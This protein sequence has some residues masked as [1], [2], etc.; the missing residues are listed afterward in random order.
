VSF[1]HFLTIGHLDHECLARGEAGALR[2]MNPELRAVILDRAD[3]GS[4]RDSNG[5]V[6]F[7][8]AG[9][10][11]TMAGEIARLP[12]HEPRLN[13]SAVALALIAL[14][15]GHDAADVE[16]A[17]AVPRGELESDARIQM[18]SPVVVPDAD[19]PSEDE[20][21]ALVDHVLRAAAALAPCV[22][23]ARLT[24]APHAQWTVS[25][26][27]AATTQVLDQSAGTFRM[28]LAR[29][30]CQY[31]D[32]QVYGG[33]TRRHLRVGARDYAAAFFLSNEAL[34]GF[35]VQIHLAPLT[36]SDSH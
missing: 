9:A 7:S 14:D 29:L 35:W 1:I 24:G 32:G 20:I 31:L 16:H 8:I 10:R 19:S 27:Q 5:R 30:A 36:G 3:A 4:V 15:L 11:G 21:I 22:L 12:W 34:S 26:T 13:H 25:T 17:R 6:E 33:Y 28:A 23:Q 18:L 2:P